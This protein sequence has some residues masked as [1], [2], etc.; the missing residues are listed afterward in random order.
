[1]TTP[2]AVD[3]VIAARARYSARRASYAQFVSDVYEAIQVLD[4]HD[5]PRFRELVKIWGQLEIIN[6]LS[7]ADGRPLSA[8]EEADADAL[9]NE[10]LELLLDDGDV[11]ES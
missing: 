7:L 2:S 9:T 5:S 11:D 4:D 10:L 8:E 1:M 3:L 6:A